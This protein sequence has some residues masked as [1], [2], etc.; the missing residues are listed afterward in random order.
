MRRPPASCRRHGP[1]HVYEVLGAAA[2]TGSRVWIGRGHELYADDGVG[3]YVFCKEEEY[4]HWH[5]GE[6]ELYGGLAVSSDCEGDSAG[7]GIWDH[8]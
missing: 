5:G 7:Q 1:Q 4:C 2:D 8:G 6:R 3:K